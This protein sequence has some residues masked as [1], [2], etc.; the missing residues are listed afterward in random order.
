M[1]AETTRNQR[2][3]HKLVLCS[4]ESLEIFGVTDVINFDEETVVLGT[5]SGGMEIGGRALHIHVLDIA[6]GVVSMSG[7]IDSISYYEQE[8]G[9]K[10]DKNSFFSKLFR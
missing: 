4:R 1:N 3:E 8:S 5:L 6:S 2:T 10:S 7:V 9:E